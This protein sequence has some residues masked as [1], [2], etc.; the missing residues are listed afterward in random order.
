MVYSMQFDSVNEVVD[1]LKDSVKRHRV[2]GN[3]QCPECLG[4]M[5]FDKVEKVYGCDKC[6]AKIPSDMK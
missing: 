3:R 5:W 1:M 2:P 6:K 4:E